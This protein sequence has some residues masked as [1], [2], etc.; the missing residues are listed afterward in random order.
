VPTIRSY[1]TDQNASWIVTG[2]PM[3]SDMVETSRYAASLQW[4]TGASLRIGDSAIARDT[5]AS[6]GLACGISDAFHLAGAKPDAVQLLLAKR[7]ADQLGSHLRSLSHALNTSRFRNESDWVHYRSFVE[8]SRSNT[9]RGEHT[10]GN[11]RENQF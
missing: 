8:Y 4:T 9:G 1:L 6:Q 10:N 7:Q 2:L 3:L 11:H 5:L